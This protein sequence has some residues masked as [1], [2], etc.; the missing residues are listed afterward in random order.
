MAMEEWVDNSQA[1]TALSNILPCVDPRT[2]NRTLVQSKEVISNIVNVVNTA[3]YSYANTD[4]SPQAINYY[5]QSEPLIPPLCS[6]F[7]SELNDRQCGPQEVSFSNASSVWQNYT[8]VTL[9]SGFC[10]TAGRITPDFY[11]QLVAAV[12]VSYAL[13][14]YAPPLLGLQDCNFVRETF[15]TITSDY[16]PPL[17]H[18]L[19]MAVAGL[20]LISAGVMLCII[21]W[22]LYANRLQREEVF[23]KQSLLISG[24][25]S[26]NIHSRSNNKLSPPRG[27]ITKQNGSHNSTDLLRLNS[28]NKCPSKGL[29]VSREKALASL[30]LFGLCLQ[31]YLTRRIC[32][33]ALDGAIKYIILD[34]II[35]NLLQNLLHHFKVQTPRKDQLRHYLTKIA[36]CF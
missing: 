32:T 12:N 25:D 18:Y 16:C 30:D 2:T 10:T 17:E 35:F 9:S 36:G 5:N 3:I 15:R 23:V 13:N 24:P 6:P 27:D 21:L 29:S 20:G 33:N 26:N 14:H 22:I 4:P 8:C 7:D 11:T 31:H 1:K 28:H 19:Q 34:E